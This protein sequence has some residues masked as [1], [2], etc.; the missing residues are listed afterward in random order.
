MKNKI[1]T[2]FQ[3]KG[4]TLIELLMIVA[5]ILLLAGVILV[6]IFKSRVRSNATAVL[7]SIKSAA[8][9]SYSC[10]SEVGLV[11]VRLTSPSD[12]GRTSMCAYN[13]GGILVDNPSYQD[14]PDITK[15]SWSLDLQPG[16]LGPDGFYWCRVGNDTVNHPIDIGHYN[17]EIYG[18]GNFSGEFCFMLKKDAM[19]IWCMPKGCRKEGF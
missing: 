12:P 18:G 15:K 19:Y 17:N 3:K 6:S 14:W 2:K 13:S 1:K 11:D 7:Y 16:P 8:S 5:I 4:F 9:A 10:L